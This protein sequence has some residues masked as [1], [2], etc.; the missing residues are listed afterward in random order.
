MTPLVY[1]I[2]PG[3]I[4][5]EYSSSLTFPICESVMM[6][7][8]RD[9]WSAPVTTRRGHHEGH[10]YRRADG[11]WEWKITLPNGE[12]RSFYGKT[13]REAREKKN[14]AIRD[15]ESGLSR[16]AE[17][18]TV[19]QYVMEWLET[20]ARERVRPSTLTAYTSHFDIH[21]K[22]AMKGIKLRDLEPDDV[23]RMLAGIVRGGATPATANRVRATLRAALASALKS[24]YVTHN[25]AALSEPRKERKTR[26]SPLTIEQARLLIADVKDDRIGP[27]VETA[28]YTGMRQGELL[29]LRWQD[30]DLEE[31]VVTVSRTL[32]WEKN[33][34]ETGPK[35]LPVFSDPKTDKSHR[36]IRLTAKAVAALERQH[37]KVI[38]LEQKATVTRWK[39]IPGEDLVFPSAFGGPLNNSNVT[40]RLQGILKRL[41]LPR[42]RFHDLRHLTASLLLAEGVDIFTVKEI[43]GHSQIA[44]TAN[45]YGHLTEK[46]ADDAASRLDRAFADDDF[47][48][49]IETLTTKLTTDAIASDDTK[50][51][52]EV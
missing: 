3:F 9:L 6:N 46:L 21:I 17:R 14:R 20:V 43:L 35:M 16:N 34:S 48:D 32:T 24:R 52:E 13:E 4:F 36:R 30:V 27:L 2:T 23:N 40:N 44:L 7:Y 11:R 49:K 18:L 31:C 50:N 25:A 33:P 8:F 10:R 1:R 42:Q 47:D 38:E 5:T 19:N 26:I 28:I 51:G 45:I 29:A 37:A 12:R 15:Y 41:E 22:P 39:P